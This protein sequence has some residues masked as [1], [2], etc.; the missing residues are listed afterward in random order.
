MARGIVTAINAAVGQMT[1]TQQVLY[2]NAGRRRAAPG[3]KR[4]AGKKKAA[5]VAKR[6]RSGSASGKRGKAAKF[7]KG[8]AAARRHMAKLRRMRRRK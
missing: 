6:R 7:V 3:R 4:R 8:S 5:R 2:A 1:P